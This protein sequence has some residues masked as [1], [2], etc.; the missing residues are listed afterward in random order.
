MKHGITTALLGDQ[1]IVLKQDVEGL[2]AN[3]DS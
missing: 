1:K 3:A 2:E